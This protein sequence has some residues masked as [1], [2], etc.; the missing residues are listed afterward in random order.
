[1]LFVVIKVMLIEAALISWY[2]TERVVGHIAHNPAPFWSSTVESVVRAPSFPSTVVIFTLRHDS[3][4]S[5]VQ[6][7]ICRTRLDCCNPVP[8][9]EANSLSTAVVTESVRA[10][11]VSDA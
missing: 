4:G 5:V 6:R 9:K 1:M 10:V 11:G 8:L 2:N 7:T 3:S